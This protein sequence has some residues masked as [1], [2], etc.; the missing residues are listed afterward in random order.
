MRIYWDAIRQRQTIAAQN[1]QMMES[2]MRGMETMLLNGMISMSAA[3]RQLEDVA[4]KFNTPMPPQ[5]SAIFTTNH[6]HT[7]S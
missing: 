2:C 1:K 4:D 3:K 5:S 6:T 7:Q